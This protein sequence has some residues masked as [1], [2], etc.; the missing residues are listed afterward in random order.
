MMR[1]R[2]PSATATVAAPMSTPRGAPRRVLCPT[3]YDTR[4]ARAC[5]RRSSSHNFSSAFVDFHMAIAGRIYLAML[6]VLNGARTS[7]LRSPLTTTTIT[8]T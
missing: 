5:F 8:H 7:P 2:P 4:T 6:R 3:V 1:F